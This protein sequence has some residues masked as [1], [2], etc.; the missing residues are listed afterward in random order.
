MCRIGRLCRRSGTPPRARP[1]G[2]LDTHVH[3]D[4]A[5][6]SRSRRRH[7]VPRFGA[8]AQ[9]GRRATKRCGRTLRCPANWGTSARGER[10]GPTPGRSP[11]RCAPW[12]V[13]LGR[14]PTP[15]CYWCCRHLRPSRRALSS[16]VARQRLGRF[17]MRRYTVVGGVTGSF[18]G[19]HRPVAGRADPAPLAEDTDSGLDRTRRRA[20]GSGGVGGVRDSRCA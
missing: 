10:H 8:L 2:R 15:G 18:R 19:R 4:L 20:H 7:S 3:A 16:A 14:K 1:N 12:E 9:V 5:Q 6:P 17:R 11:L 13:P